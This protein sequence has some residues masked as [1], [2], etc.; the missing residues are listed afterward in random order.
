MDL[1]CLEMFFQKRDQLLNKH[2]KDKYNETF[3]VVE[4]IVNEWD[5]FDL[6]AIYCPDD[7]YEFEIKRIVSANFAV[8]NAEELAGKIN[9]ILY[10]TF[11]EDFKKSQDSLAIDSILT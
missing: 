5:S 6:L 7:E 9:G 1:F 10:K 11:E 8:N 3:K 4:K 2:L